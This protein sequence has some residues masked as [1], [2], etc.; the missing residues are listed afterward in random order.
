L[1]PRCRPASTT[2][3]HGI[4]DF[5]TNLYDSK[6]P[7]ELSEKIYRAEANTEAAK[8][9][10]TRI[11]PYTLLAILGIALA[12][13]NGFLT[14]I[15]INGLPDPDGGTTANVDVLSSLNPLAN[16][17]GSN[18]MD[19]LQQAGFG[20][21]LSNPLYKFL[22]TNKIGGALCLLLGG[23]SAL[24]AEAEFD[25]KRINVEK[26][27]EEL[28]RRRAQKTASSSSSTCRAKQS[29]KQKKSL[30]ALSE[31]LVAQ[32]KEPTATQEDTS[33]QVEPEPSSDAVDDKGGIFG[34]VI[35]LYKKQTA[36]RH[37]KR[38]C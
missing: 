18:N 32:E 36:W 38:C 28:E 14:E 1:N 33:I 15:R 26:I 30:K 7:P 35:D 19:I 9:Q 27:Y 31:V 11:A 29:G 12:F 24:L 22:F 34:K 8:D 16:P 37:L 21:V 10:G 17:G 4:F 5:L 3:L 6:I 20:W 25:S 23:G 2:R 13:F